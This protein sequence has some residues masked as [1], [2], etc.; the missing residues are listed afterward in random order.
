MA[1]TTTN[2]TDTTPSSA[3][4]TSHIPQRYIFND[5]DMEHFRASPVYADFMKFTQALGQ[6]CSKKHND[7]NHDNDSNQ[8]EYDPEHPLRGLSPAMA[9]VHGI[10]T[11]LLTWMQE[12]D[13]APSS[14]TLSSFRFGDPT[15]QQWHAR[16]VQRSTHMVQAIL[17]QHA[18]TR[19]E[20]KT[21]SKE[22]QD[23]TEEPVATDDDD[24]DDDADDDQD[25]EQTT[26]RTA[27]AAGQQS[28]RSILDMAKITDAHDRAAIVEMATYLQAAFGHPQRLDYGT[29]HE[30]S[31]HVF[32]Y[33]LWRV[34]CWQYDT[35]T[36]NSFSTLRLKATT[37][38][39]YTAYL[40]VT[41]QLQT[42]YSLEPAGSHGVWGLDDYHCLPFYFGACQLSAAS[43]HNNLLELSPPS[44]IGDS[45][46]VQAHKDQYLYLSCIDYIQQLKKG[47]PFFESSPMLHDISQ[48]LPSWSKVAAGLLKLYQGEVL[49][50]RPVVQHLTFGKVFAANWTPSGHAPKEPP[51]ETLFRNNDVGMGRAPWATANAASPMPPMGRA[52]WATA[53]TRPPVM[54]TAAAMPPTRAPWAKAPSSSV[55]SIQTTT[56]L[57]NQTGD[58]VEKKKDASS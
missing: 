21:K 12:P 31:F 5:A 40:Q 18:A 3:D 52:P 56:T 20:H 33:T 23:K 55:P 51:N 13:L 29:G 42:C 47:V 37:I 25:T 11:E 58:A 15:F 30:T 26:L 48:T 49:Q 45:A 7:S 38:S 44:C 46:I 16:L 17:V 57:P 34:G 39:L 22:Q 8:Y 28:T 2:N 10:L 4:D 27:H 53:G 41:R 9:C 19:E 43:F 32:L 54:N 35:T 36:T 24:D 14:G 50:K 6:S 1:T